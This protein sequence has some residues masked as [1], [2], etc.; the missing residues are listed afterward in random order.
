MGAAVRVGCSGCPCG[1]VLLAG[2]RKDTEGAWKVAA[3]R[4]EGRAAEQTTLTAAAWR[5]ERRLAAAPEARASCCRASGRQGEVFRP[6][7][8]LGARG[9]PQGV[10]A[11][12]PAGP[13]LKEAAMAALPGSDRCGCCQ[14]AREPGSALVH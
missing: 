1:R 7:L 6:L 4:R 3:A 9:A 10:G 13:Q 14:R 8:L 12:R 5:M 2:G 11:T